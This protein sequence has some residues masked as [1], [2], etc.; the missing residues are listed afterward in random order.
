MRLFV[1]V[2]CFPVEQKWSVAVGL[3]V[4]GLIVADGVALDEGVEDEEDEDK[5]VVVV[6]V[7]VVAVDLTL[8][9]NH[10]DKKNRVIQRSTFQYKSNSMANC[11]R[12]A[13]TNTEGTLLNWS[14]RPC[15]R[16]SRMLSSIN[17]ISFHRSSISN[18]SCSDRVTPMTKQEGTPMV[19]HLSIWAPMTLNGWHCH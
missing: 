17:I 3:I 13:S 8:A 5:D 6:V 19:Q 18:S 4:V 11:I 10:D 1:P 15:T 16:L 9:F 14:T 2:I 12:Y 7:D